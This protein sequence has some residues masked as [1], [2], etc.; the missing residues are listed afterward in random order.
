MAKTGRVCV[1]PRSTSSS[2]SFGDGS[3]VPALRSL[4]VVA[5]SGSARLSIWFSSAASRDSSRQTDPASDRRVG[6]V[7]AA[8]SLPSRSIIVRSPRYAMIDFVPAR[9]RTHRRSQRA[10]AFL[11]TEQDR[12]D[13][14]RRLF[15]LGSTRAVS[16]DGKCTEAAGSPGMPW[17][18]HAPKLAPSMRRS[19]EGAAFGDLPTMQT[20]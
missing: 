20:W 10:G 2:V 4:T 6:S 7:A 14:A 15:A 8:S 19:A 12:L 5:G 1:I 11:F 16:S 18:P 13:S 17:V 9:E 3:G